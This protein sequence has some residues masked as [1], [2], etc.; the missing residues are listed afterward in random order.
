MTHGIGYAMRESSLQFFTY[1]FSLIAAFM[2][3][4][5]IQTEVNKTVE[6]SERQWLRWAFAIVVS[7][8]ALFVIAS[9]N[10][11]HD[12][13]TDEECNPHLESNASKPKV[14]SS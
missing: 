12:S 3:N 5:A 13:V 11:Y 4:T 7:L 2:V 6:A 9:I 10:M 1:A 8:I 14:G